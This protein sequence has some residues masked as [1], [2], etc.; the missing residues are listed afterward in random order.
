MGVSFKGGNVAD[1]GWSYSMPPRNAPTVAPMSKEHK[2][3]GYDV[4]ARS[5]TA[6]T[7]SGYVTD[8][9]SLGCKSTHPLDISP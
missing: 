9:S 4:S 6:V 8:S 3:A 5:P 2:K 7:Y 1:K